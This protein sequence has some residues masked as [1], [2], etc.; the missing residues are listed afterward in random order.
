M[1]FGTMTNT[2]INCNG[3][4]VSIHTNSLRP[5]GCCPG[6][7]AFSPGCFGFGFKPVCG[8]PY[9]FGAGAALGFAAGAAMT[10]LLPGV[11]KGIGKGCSWLWNN[12]LVPAAKGIWSGM[13]WIGNGIANGAAWL[14]NGMKTLWNKIF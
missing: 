4:S 2:F 11:F 1:G 10:P 3:Y 6:F 9:M 13:K 5:F 8:N 12:A 14:W 7:R